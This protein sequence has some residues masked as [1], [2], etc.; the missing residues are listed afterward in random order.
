MLE[1]RKRIPMIQETCHCILYLRSNRILDPDDRDAGQIGDNFSFVIPV[2]L[3][4]A[5]QITIT[6]A[7]GS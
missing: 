3:G 1:K 2:R 4:V 6:D 5:G 7:D